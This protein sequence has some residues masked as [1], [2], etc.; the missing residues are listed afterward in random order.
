[1][2]QTNDPAHAAENSNQMPFPQSR[3]N[4]SVS[5]LFKERN[6]AEQAVAD[7]LA[8]GFTD[9]QIG[10]AQ[11]EASD[12][13]TTESRTLGHLPSATAAGGAVGGGLL[14]GTLGVLTG[15]GLLAIPGVGPVLAGGLLASV[16]A[17]VSLGSAGGSLLGALVGTG[18][19]EEEA[20]H[21]ESGLRG[22]AVLVTVHT[23]DR[24]QEALSILKHLGAD[25]G[26]RIDVTKDDTSMPKD[27]NPVETFSTE[28][29]QHVTLSA[30]ELSIHKVN[31]ELGKVTI[32]KEVITETRM[33]EV[34][35]QREE[36]VIESQDLAE[37]SQVNSVRILLKEEQVSLEKKV[38]VR[39]EVD[40][41]KH[42]ITE[43]Q[44]IEETLKR[45]EL[46]IETG[47][48]IT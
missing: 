31:I 28:D 48:D 30:E 20:R 17:G 45:E 10:V 42:E 26:K 43:L 37:G 36:L 27:D 34:P 35:V 41:S 11:R 14:G 24:V 15:I 1:M 21:L 12:L 40:V 38:V 32:R 22:G 44:R 19:S 4:R 7:L 3:A 46:H 2:V 39:E 13:I 47:N 33:I 16:L 9:E 23:E 18:L 25:T 6:L 5:G 29:A 8:A